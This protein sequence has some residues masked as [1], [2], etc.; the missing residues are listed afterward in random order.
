MLRPSL[1][2]ET[3]FI[4]PKAHKAAF[5]PGDTKHLPQIEEWADTI[6]ARLWDIALAVF[7]DI[8]KNLYQLETRVETL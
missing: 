3:W 5:T 7:V 2:S 4:K 8:R 1:H 6:T